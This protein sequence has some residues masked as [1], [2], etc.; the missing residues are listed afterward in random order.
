MGQPRGSGLWRRRPPGRG[1]RGVGPDAGA[2]TLKLAVIPGNEPAVTLYQRHGFGF[3][4]ELGY[5]LSDD[6]VRE[7]LMARNLR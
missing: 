7:R 2:T 6:G 4:G 1:G 5:L 3:S